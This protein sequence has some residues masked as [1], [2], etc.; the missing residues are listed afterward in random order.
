MTVCLALAA[1]GQSLSNTPPLDA[2]WDTIAAPPPSGPRPGSVESAEAESVIPSLPQGRR[3]QGLPM[4]L[5]TVPAAPP[6]AMAPT[7]LVPAVAAVTAL[8]RSELARDPELRRFLILGRL[9]D[10]GLASPDD[11]DRRRVANLGA[12][13]PFSAAPPAAGLELP[14]PSQDEM[15]QRMAELVR[16][17]KGTAL[18]RDAER[19][20]LLEGLLPLKPQA[21]A[22]PVRTDAEALRLGRSRID[23][24]AGAELVTPAEREAE[25]AAITRAE[26]AIASQPL[27]PPAPPPAKPVKKKKATAGVVPGLD[28]PG[29]GPAGVHLLSMASAALEDRAWEGLKQQHSELAALEHKVIKTVIPDL[30]TTYRLLAGPL[31]PADAELLCRTLRTKGQSCSV[32]KY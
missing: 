16:G 27:P 30:G 10:D 22:P 14:L 19:K 25:L 6:V 21:K 24:L 31:P 5:T 3:P 12:L 8:D 9:V 4:P 15:L 11:A 13:L 20:F 23:L 2:S 29:A 17:T 28:A 18:A 1:C 26:E 32:A 7:P